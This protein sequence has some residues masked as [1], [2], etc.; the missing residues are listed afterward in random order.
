MQILYIFKKLLIIKS[1][2]E[3]ASVVDLYWLIH[4]WV[5]IIMNSIFSARLDSINSIPIFGFYRC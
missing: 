2:F 1:I 3:N 4:Q 5:N